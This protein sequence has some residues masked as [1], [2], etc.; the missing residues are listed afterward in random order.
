MGFAENNRISHRQLARQ[1]FL[2]L[3]SPFLLCLV[4]G[5]GVLGISGIAGAVICFL[6]LCFYVIFLIRIAPCFEDLTKPLGAFFGKAAG[7]IYLI[8]TITTASYLLAVVMEIIPENLL[9]GASRYLVGILVAVVCSLGTHKGMQKRG[10]MAEVSAGIFLLSILFLL[11][12]AVFEGSWESLQQIER[13][14]PSE[15]TVWIQDAY[16]IFCGF[17]G[18]GMVPFL[19][20]DVEK[21]SS[22]KKP[23]LW[24]VAWL[25][26]ILIGIL[27]ILPAVFGWERLVQEKYPILPMLAGTNLPGDVLSRFDVIWLAF[28]LYGLLFSIGSLM[29]YG[30][31]ILRSARI[32]NGRFWMWPVIFAAAV[33][34][35]G[36]KTVT[37]YYPELL[38]GWLV[39]L[40]LLIQLLI[41]LFYRRRTV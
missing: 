10:R 31:Q 4:G 2:A 36:G 29:F 32:G 17:S 7:I 33:L 15:G 39:P 40:L 23:I 14:I 19:L 27:L 18:I 8:Y 5:S 28:I 25:T 24:A 13:S 37:E 26:G 34:P 41:I 3:A 20:K 1:I 35:V 16:K 30:N 12:L 22:T 6:V 11:L 38:T 9:I 21:P